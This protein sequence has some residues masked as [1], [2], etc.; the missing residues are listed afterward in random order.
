VDFRRVFAYGGGP[1]DG[2]HALHEKTEREPMSGKS[3]SG[4]AC[5]YYFMNGELHPLK[6]GSCFSDREKLLRLISAEQAFILKQPGTNY[7]RIW[8]DLYE[9][10]LDS[11][12]IRALASHIQAI[13]RTIYRLCFVGCSPV[14]A[15]RIRRRLKKLGLPIAGAVKFFSDPED[16]KKWLIGESR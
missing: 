3:P 5:P 4:S 2:K 1:S 12:A 7:R 11:E 13:E 16:A 10:R 6:Y 15:W 9:T 14:G 8:I